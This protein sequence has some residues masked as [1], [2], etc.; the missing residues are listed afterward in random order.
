MNGS[1]ALHLASANG[2]DKIVKLLLKY[3]ADK[4]IP[5]NVFLFNLER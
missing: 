4:H 5:D 1:T 3:G 2:K